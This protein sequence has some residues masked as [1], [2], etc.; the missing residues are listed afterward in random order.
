[1]GL[2]RAAQRLERTPRV[3]RACADAQ[4]LKDFAVKPKRVVAQSAMV[5]LI[6]LA[7]LT[8]VAAN[9]PNPPVQ[10]PP[11]VPPVQPLQPTAS[12][13]DTPWQWQSTR[14]ADGTSTT[15]ADPTRYTIAFDGDGSL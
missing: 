7:S 1:M 3:Q 6:G 14:H 15:A 11:Q 2:R 10:L 4:D 13:S 9:Q 8:T 5:L 12:L